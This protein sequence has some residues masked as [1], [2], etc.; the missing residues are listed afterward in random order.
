MRSEIEDIVRT[1]DEALFLQSPRFD[2]YRY[3]LADEYRRSPV[4]PAYHAGRAYP[5]DPDALRD[6]LNSFFD[7]PDGPGPVDA[8]TSGSSVAGIL[9]PHI[10][11]QRGGPVY[12]WGYRALAEAEPADLYLVLGVPHHGLDGPAAATLKAYDTPLGTLEV[13][14]DFVAGLQRRSRADLLSGELSH[15]TEHSIE[16]ETVF[17]RHLFGDRDIRIAPILTSFVQEQM[18][19]GRNP[20]E[21]P[22]SE[23]F[24]DANVAWGSEAAIRKRIQEH[25]DAGADHVCIQ[26]INPDGTR[27]PDEKILAMLAPGG[28]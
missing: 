7:H 21:D 10:D 14:Q 13:D 25:W 23:R 12:A 11:F 4:R 9:A 26:S 22:E 15:R 18:A 16:F 8:T 27:R 28:G 20:R 19:Q 6:W 5:S 1:L 17:L 2:A 24:I 3:G